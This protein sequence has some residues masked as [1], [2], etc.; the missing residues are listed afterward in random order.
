MDERIF[1]I[2]YVIKNVT[3]KFNRAACCSF[4]KIWKRD[5][6]LQY[7]Y[8]RLGPIPDAIFQSYIE[9]VFVA[10]NV[11][12]RRETRRV[13]VKGYTLGPTD[14][15]SRKTDTKENAA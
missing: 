8:P 6:F 2:S 13:K 7:S 10:D 5:R 9:Y 14:N 3:S 12:R 1:V 15:G 4:K 11:A